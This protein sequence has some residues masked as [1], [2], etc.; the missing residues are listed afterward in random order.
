MAGRRAIVGG[1]WGC[2]RE[3]AGSVWAYDGTG[4]R[5]GAEVVAPAIDVSLVGGAETWRVFIV[6]EGMVVGVIEGLGLRVNNTV[7]ERSVLYR[8]C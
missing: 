4:G 6:G 3:V 8:K 5:R 1:R 7:S 2:R